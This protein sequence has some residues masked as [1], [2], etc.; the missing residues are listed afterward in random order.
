MQNT[1]HHIAVNL[2]PTTKPTDTAT[3]HTS[4]CSEPK[5][6]TPS[7]AMAPK[8][9]VHCALELFHVPF[10]QQCTGCSLERRDGEI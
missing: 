6:G 9:L 1:V 7:A 2:S 8:A 10:S 3:T 5:Q 4:V